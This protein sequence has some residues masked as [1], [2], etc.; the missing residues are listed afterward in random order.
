LEVSKQD[1]NIAVGKVIRRLRNIKGLSQTKIGE[2]ADVS[3]QQIQKY[4]RASN[5]V[6]IG[7]LY[8]IADCLGVKVEDIIKEV[9]KE[10]GHPQIV[11]DPNSEESR[12]ILTLYYSLSENDKELIKH[13]IASWIV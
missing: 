7:V 11:F 12:D 2:H 1:Y 3:F 4:E 8:K 6:S 9:D 5:R 13:K 10:V